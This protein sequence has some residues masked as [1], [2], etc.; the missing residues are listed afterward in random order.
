MLNNLPVI[1]LANNRRVDISL[2]ATGQQSVHR[3]PF[4]A[5]DALELISEKGVEEQPSKKKPLL[6][7]W[8]SPGLLNHAQPGLTAWPLDFAS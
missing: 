7:K 1:V 4:N 2:S 5:N 6:K 3:Y 8:R